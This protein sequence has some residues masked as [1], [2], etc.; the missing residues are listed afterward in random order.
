MTESEHA[1]ASRRW[2]PWVVLMAALVTG[3][4]MPSPSG[5]SGGGSIG[6]GFAIPVDLAKATVTL[7][8]RP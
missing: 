2:S 7:A 4:T 5:E 3:A 8:A 6:L 1:R